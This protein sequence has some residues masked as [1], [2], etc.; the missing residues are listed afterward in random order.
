[1]GIKVYFQ[2]KYFIV[3]RYDVDYFISLGAGPQNRTYCTTH[4]TE[5][6]WHL[7]L[8]EQYFHLNMRYFVLS[9][10]GIGSEI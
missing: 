4:P 6:V 1:M 9:K 5:K 2:G 8:I 10:C 7:I 3:P